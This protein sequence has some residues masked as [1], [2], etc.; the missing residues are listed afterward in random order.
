VFR[1]SRFNPDGTFFQTSKV[2]R[3]IRLSGDGDEFAAN[4]SV[5]VFDVNDVLVS[6]GLRDRSRNTPSL[7]V[8]KGV[9]DDLGVWAVSGDGP[10]MLAMF[11]SFKMEVGDVTRA[12]PND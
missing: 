5:K 4:A 12:S 11:S 1:Y 7:R 6:K 9:V 10:F 2:T 8:V 3:Q